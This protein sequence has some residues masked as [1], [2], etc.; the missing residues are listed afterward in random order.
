MKFGSGRFRIPRNFERN[1]SW[2]SH[3]TLIDSNAEVD[4]SELL[5][6]LKLRP[7]SCQCTHIHTHTFTHTYSEPILSQNRNKK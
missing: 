4:A 3:S 1:I 5:E 6:N 7:K 2:D